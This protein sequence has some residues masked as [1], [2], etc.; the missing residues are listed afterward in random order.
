LTQLAR[1]GLA[2]FPEH[3]SDLLERVYLEDTFQTACAQLGLTFLSPPETLPPDL[4]F[5]LSDPLAYLRA[6]AIKREIQTTPLKFPS[7][8]PY[9]A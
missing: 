3:W 6:V 7:R 9:T 5:D 2:P 8:L 1:W 4:L